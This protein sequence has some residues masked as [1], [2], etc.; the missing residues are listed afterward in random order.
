MHRHTINMEEAN[1][2]DVID[3]GT[4][5]NSSQSTPD[6]QRRWPIF[7]YR[8]CGL[9]ACV[10]VA[11]CAVVA[12]FTAVFSVHN[13]KFGVCINRSFVLTLSVILLY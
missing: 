12:V 13:Q 4:N 6:S 5:G 7:N 11:L 10:F 1:L 9:L 2:A 3:R 8:V